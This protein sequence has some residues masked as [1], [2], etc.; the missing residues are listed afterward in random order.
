MSSYISA[1][2]TANPKHRIKQS[3]ILE[4]MTRA[5]GLDQNNALR[6]KKIYDHSGIDYRYSVIPDFGEEDFDNHKFFAKNSTLEPFPCTQ[7][8]LKLY[9]QTAA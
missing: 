5:F 7:N 9:Q 8:R 3:S 1:I 6:L 4:F 2:G